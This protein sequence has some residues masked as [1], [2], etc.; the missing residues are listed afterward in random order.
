MYSAAIIA[1][2]PSWSDRLGGLLHP[3]AHVILLSD[4][5]G[6][7]IEAR[8]AGFELRDT[9][10]LCWPQLSSFAFLLR[11]PFEGTT[12]IQVETSGSG[13]LNVDACRIGA[14]TDELVVHSGEQAPFTEAHEGYKRPGRSMYTH[15]PK[16]RTGPANS[17]GRWPANIV[18]IH[19]PSCRRAGEA[20]VE[21]HKGYPHGPGGSSTQFSQKGT[22]TTRKGAWAGHADADGLETVAVWA[23]QPNCPVGLLN[24]QSGSLTSGAEKIGSGGASRFYPQFATPWELL[25]W[26]RTLVAVPLGDLLE[27]V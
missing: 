22:A 9:L 27:K 14:H 20:R 10:L 26:L 4:H 3:G 15:K 21:G 2:R 12:H 17:L 25:G 23:C 19:G 6:H 5:E 13:A 11:R 24:R 8:Q 7:A 1:A 18:F 16:E